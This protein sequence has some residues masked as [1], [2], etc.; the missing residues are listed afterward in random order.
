VRGDE[1]EVEDGCYGQ[2]EDDEFADLVHVGGKGCLWEE[3]RE[4]RRVV[5]EGYL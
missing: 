2:D 4:L 3:G 5:G 1:C